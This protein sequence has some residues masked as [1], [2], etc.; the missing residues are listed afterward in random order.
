MTS[1]TTRGFGSVIKAV[2]PRWLTL[3]IELTPT[4]SG[5]SLDRA[6]FFPSLWAS[7]R[8]KRLHQPGRNKDDRWV[9]HAGQNQF[10]RSREC[11]TAAA[12]NFCP[13]LCRTNSS[14][15]VTA[16]RSIPDQPDSPSEKYLFVRIKSATREWAGIIV[17]TYII[18]HHKTRSECSA[19][20]NNNDEKK[21]W[22]IAR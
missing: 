4:V 18:T 7:T 10:D 19:S 2:A 1:S 17:D 12:I 8:A 11:F 3:L 20:R 5:L 6:G 22:K 16:Q 14:G 15:F 9:H 13:L 21:K